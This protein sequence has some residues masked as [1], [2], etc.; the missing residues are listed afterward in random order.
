MK[1]LAA[2][3]MIVGVVSTSS[4]VVKVLWDFETGLGGWGPG[5]GTVS[6][7]TNPVSGSPC[8]VLVSPPAGWQTG[9]YNSSA[10]NGLIDLSATPIIQFEVT[11]VAS[12][13]GDVGWITQDNF[14]INSGGGWGQKGLVAGFDGSWGSWAGDATRI[15]QYDYTGY[16]LSGGWSQLSIMING[17]SPTS[18]I[19]GNYYIDNIVAIGPD[20]VT[21]WVRYECED[22]Q[23]VDAAYINS[24]AD[25]SGGQ[26]V[27]I[28]KIN[29]AQNGQIV[30]TANAPRAGTY[31]MRY[32]QNAFDKER[33]ENFFVNGV[34]VMDQQ[35]AGNI[36]WTPAEAVVGNNGWN[37]EALITDLF[38]SVTLY[39]EQ[40]GN[41]QVWS[42]WAPAWNEA[43]VNTPMTV[44]LNEGKNTISIVAL[45]GWDDWDYIELELGYIAKNPLPA[46]DGIAI[47]GQDTALEWKN[48]LLNLDKVEVW[49]GQTPEP[50]AADPNTFITSANYKKKLTLLGS[51]ANPSDRSSLPMP[52]L[53]NG[54]S[55]TWVADG[56]KGVAEGGEPN[57]PGVFWTFMAT[58]NVPPTAN[59][60]VDQ[61]VWLAPSS[62]VVTLDGS[63]ST[64][65]GLD[66]P[67]SY[68]WS[69]TAGPAVTLDT[70][71]A[72]ATTVTMTVLGNN[73]E[74]GTAAPYQF[75][76]TVNDGLWSRS[77][78]VT[79]YVNSN[80]CTASI[81]AG[82]FY[83]AADISSAQ[84]GVRDCKVD[85]YD[86]LRFAGD[87]LSCSNIFE[88][89]P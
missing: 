25:C 9:A 7:G 84:E 74:A 24:D 23:L 81:E 89:C 72:A 12:E 57:Y 80:S 6:L 47:I 65:D 55:Y 42:R 85:L 2:I 32:G 51:I 82:S 54:L 14:V 33:Y 21:P 83:Y 27:S 11:Y 61:Y 56:F 5:G 59:A 48:A 88:A 79:V 50:N 10:G 34:L 20:P 64:D 15:V 29:D 71:N 76:L 39:G 78:T 73:T 68:Q 22:A 77:D 75:R 44:T 43:L 45:W 60:G 52:A 18:G 35:F 58:N 49:F 66:E 62:V 36:T 40:D 4:G 26:Y 1:R 8:M 41:W 16:N 17:G 87:W 30:V 28:R 31:N 53:T 13:W 19:R 86:F 67:L 46:D 37:N 38:N 69:Q 63:G 3:L 70:P